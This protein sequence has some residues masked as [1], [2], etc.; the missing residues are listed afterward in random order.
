M[1]AK[2]KKGDTVEVIAGKDKGAKGTVLEVIPAEMVDRLTARGGA[3]G[4]AEMVRE[5][6][7]DSVCT[8]VDTEMYK[9]NAFEMLDEAGVYICVNT[10]LAGAIRSGSAGRRCIRGRSARST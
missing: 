7:Y 4:Y 6:E 5:Y 8:A 9:L 2:I 3:T 1:A 10:M